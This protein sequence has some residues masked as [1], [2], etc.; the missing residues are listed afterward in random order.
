MGA[1]GGICRPPPART[2]NG[3]SGPSVRQ[4]VGYLIVN[5]SDRS[6]NPLAVGSRRYELAFLTV[7]DQPFEVMPMNSGY[8]DLG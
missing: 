2:M 4:C 3:R 8:S 1:G 7:I 5:A 6:D